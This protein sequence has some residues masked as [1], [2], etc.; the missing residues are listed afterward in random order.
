MNNVE[1][2]NE[3]EIDLDY[4]ETMRNLINYAI[5]YEKIKNV[6]FNI[7]IVD[8][9]Y[10]HKL[11]K[12]YRGIDRPT[13]VISFALEDNADLIQ[14]NLRVLGDIYI[15]IDKVYEQAKEYGHSNLREICFLMIHGFL[16]LLGYDHMEEA[17]EKVMFAKQEEILNGFGITR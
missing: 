13:D 11:N 1:I 7:I 16:H 14:S 9:N 2:I 4:I 3:T 10:I 15:S 5:E 12:E 8:N 6:I 17:E